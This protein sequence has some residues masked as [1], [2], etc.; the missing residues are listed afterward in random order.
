MLTRLASSQGKTQGVISGGA[1]NELASKTIHNVHKI[2]LHAATGLRSPCPCCLLSRG[3]SFS[4]FGVFPYALALGPG[5]PSSKVKAEPSHMSNIH[6]PATSSSI[7]S[8]SFYF[9]SPLPF[10]FS[11][12]LT[13]RKLYIINVYSFMF[14]D[15]YIP[16]KWSP[17][18]IP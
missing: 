13:Y 6:S 7:T 14:R 4:A 2:Q 17:H 8:N 12:F 18:S 5:L 3:G 1:G 10:F 15:K 9:L 11:F 16:M